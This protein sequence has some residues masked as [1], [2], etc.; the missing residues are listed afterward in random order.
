MR[1]TVVDTLATVVFFT[2]LASLTELTI[3][4]MEPSEVLTTR[5]V[6]IPLMVLT[7]RPYGAWRDWFFGVTGPTVRWSRALI[8]G[9]AFLSFQLPVYALTLWVAGAEAGAIMTLLATTSVL[10]FAVSRPFGLFL[11]LARRLAGVSPGGMGPERQE[12]ARA[13]R[14]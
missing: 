1:L 9:L 11:E 2:V 12:Q 5:L 4:G 10:M 8:D 13:S 6:M 3:G 7:G 14:R